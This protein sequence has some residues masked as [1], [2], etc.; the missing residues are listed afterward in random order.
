MKKL[1][2]AAV[3][4]LL[5]STAM[6]RD[7]QARIVNG[8]QADAT[9]YP[10]FATVYSDIYQCGGSLIHPRWVLSAAHCFD[11]GQA[12]GTVDV[13]IGAQWLS[14]ATASQTIKAVGVYV[15]P[16]FDATTLDY[17]YALVEL[18]AASSAPVLKLAAPIQTPPAGVM[19]RVVGHGRT[20][21]PEGYFDDRY[22]P[23]VSCYA[24]LSACIA[25][26]R[27]KGASDTAMIET[28]LLAN[29]LGDSAQGIGYR[30]LWTQSTL[31]AAAA[32][33]VA[34]L[35]GAYL[36]AGKTLADMAAI[37]SAAAGVTDELREVD[38]PIADSAA[39]AADTGYTLTANML[40]AGYG[41]TS[42]IH[43]DSCQGDSGGPLVVR[44]ATNTDWLQVGVVSY[45]FTCA[46]TYGAYAKVASQFD[47]IGQYVPNFSVDRVLAWG[48]QTET[49]LLKPTGSERSTT[50]GNYYGRIYP[51]S[52]TAVGY[53]TLDR[54]LYFHDGRIL[55]PLG[56]FSGWL[57]QAK[58]AGY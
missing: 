42:G 1:A 33:S 4:L 24:S 10:W 5:V 15:H 47:W 16:Q 20:A 57:S 2:L 39:C 35:V 29:G 18:S 38:L 7:P 31:T 6:A 9:T 27:Q 53:N 45:G 52:G 50:L 43:K 19:A 28:F 8:S 49:A 46:T 13:V 40:C 41:S 48:E 56:A 36:A 34:Q 55:L 26:A 17:D 54:K 11:P 22:A 25:A 14:A 23:N 51:A 37:V 3:T 21:A 44:N 30:E 32:P 12:P 58:T